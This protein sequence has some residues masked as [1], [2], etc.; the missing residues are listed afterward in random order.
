MQ[1][2]Y[3]E[4]IAPDGYNW[5]IFNWDKQRIPEKVIMSSENPMMIQMGKSNGFRTIM[6]DFGMQRGLKHYF[7]IKV[8]QGSLMKIGV[9]RQTAPQNE[10]FCDTEEGWGIYNGQLR[11][12]RQC[13]GQKYADGKSKFKPGDVISV[14]LDMDEGTLSFTKNGVYLGEAF[15]SEELKTGTFYPAVAPIYEK[16]SFEIRQPQ[17]ED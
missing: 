14:M 1:S 16:D 6:G 2:D 17:P 5:V 10:A 3:D 11:H 12:G 9:C 4:D 13:N 7:Q 8:N 15:R